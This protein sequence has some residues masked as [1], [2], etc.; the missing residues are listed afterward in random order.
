MINR[1][2]DAGA[3]LVEDCQAFDKLSEKEIMD[4]TQENVCQFFTVLYDLKK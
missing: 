2:I 1:Y 3:L 4:R